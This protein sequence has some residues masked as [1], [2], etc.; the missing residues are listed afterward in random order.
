MFDVN[1][2]AVLESG[3]Y[4]G[5][6]VEAVN[7]YREPERP[8]EQ[9]PD[10]RKRFAVAL[11]F[12]HRFADATLRASERLYADDWGIKAT[13]TDA[14]FM[15]DITKEFRVWPHLRFHAQSGASFYRLAYAVLDVGGQ[16]AIPSIRTGDRELGPLI[17]L[18]VGAGMHFGL[19][20]RRQYGITLS[21]DFI[22]TRFLNHLFVKQRLAGFGALGFE[23]E[24][25]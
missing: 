17:G 21:G 23:A 14:R 1:T 19:G 6:T 13:T 22:Y 16:R 10:G 8:L 18:T 9:L 7:L 25:E 11:S 12:A 24:F 4:E 15:Y 3:G 2:Q 5:F 20:E